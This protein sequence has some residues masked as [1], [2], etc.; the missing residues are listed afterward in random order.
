MLRVA[1]LISTLF[2]LNSCSTKSFE[3]SVTP[4]DNGRFNTPPATDPDPTPP[5]APTGLGLAAGFVTGASPISSPAISWTNPSGDYKNV[6][7]SLG[8]SQGDTNFVYWTNITKGLTTHTFSG[9]TPVECTNYYPTVRSIDDDSLPSA[10]LTTAS[11]FYWDNTT[12]VL[13]GNIYISNFQATAT[14]SVTLNLAQL[15]KTD[16][17]QLSHL[18]FAIGYDDELNGFD[19]G[20]IENVQSYIEASG[21]STIT[22]YQLQNGVDSASFSLVT[23]R[24][25]YITVRLKDN[26]NLTSSVVVTSN[27]WRVND[28][29]LAS[30][31]NSRLSWVNGSGGGGKVVDGGNG[32]SNAG[33]AG[34]GNNDSI[35]MSA[36]DDIIFADGSGGGGGTGFT[37]GDTGGNGGSAGVGNDFIVAGA[38][39]DIIFADG[40]N[41]SNGGSD[42]NTIGGGGGYGGGGG[43]GSSPIVASVGLGGIGAGNGGGGN[44]GL[45]TDM[46]N[47]A[48]NATYGGGTAG[49]TPAQS[50]GSGGGGVS[51]T[52]AGNDGDGAGDG[53]TVEPGNT[54]P[55]TIDLSLTLL[56]TQVLNDVNQGGG[57][58]TR[59]FSQTQGSGN[60]TIIAGNGDD[61]I[62]LGN[63][64][65]LLI[66]NNSADGTDE[67]FNFTAGGG[68]DQ[69][70]LRNL[71]S[72][73]TQG[74]SNLAD[75][76]SVSD[77]GTD[78]TVT[79]DIDGTGGGTTTVVI[80][81]K[82]I[83][84]NYATLTSNNLS[85]K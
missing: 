50:F 51:T 44:S 23:N 79:I 60:D 54:T 33:G 62:F 56:Y 52:N 30:A 48:T 41:G 43:G 59:L 84:T 71:L 75:Y 18:E 57:A 19:T 63:G 46:P 38:G 78:T 32:T 10:N 65:D 53:T 36:Y 13:S 69:I 20:D 74:V 16:N 66:Y 45:E 21:G 70:E 49:A 6:Q 58:D 82:S 73:Y 55:L 25:Y 29:N 68:G 81:L 61:F 15:S 17:C 80:I 24:D 12:P 85:V 34:A 40:F 4:K 8:T 35:I 1:L 72:N 9:L 64:S 2:F 39:N 31:G 7:V 37:P 67:V 22:S 26:A 11:N 14:T 5:N 27:P 3:E 76:I 28:L 47:A 77:N 83:V 42:K